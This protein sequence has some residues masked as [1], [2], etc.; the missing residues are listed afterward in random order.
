[1]HLLGWWRSVPPLRALLD[2]EGEVDK[3]AAVAAV[4]VPGAQLAPLF[5][6]AVQWRPRPDRAMLWDVRRTGTVLVP[7]A[8]NEDPA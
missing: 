8:E 4:D 1:V 5:G 7:F 3:V 2:P 6:R